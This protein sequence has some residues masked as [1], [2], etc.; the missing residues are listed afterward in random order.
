MMQRFRD[1]RTAEQVVSGES[2]KGK[3]RGKGRRGDRAA[4]G[5]PGGNPADGQGPKPP[6][7]AAVGEAAKEKGGPKKVQPKLAA[8]GGF[9]AIH[10][11]VRSM[12]EQ[13]DHYRSRVDRVDNTVELGDFFGRSDAHQVKGSEPC[14]SL[15]T[16]LDLSDL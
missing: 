7:V 10:E 2:D 13:I 11:E 15:G 4:G 16:A 6:E 1:K 14:Y 9:Y 5:K 8:G 3:G 12:A